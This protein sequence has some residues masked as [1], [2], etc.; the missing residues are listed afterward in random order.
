MAGAGAPATLRPGGRLVPRAA[1]GG[2]EHFS[3]RGGGRVPPP[4]GVSTISPGGGRGGGTSCCAARQLPVVA[5]EPGSSG[6]TASALLLRLTGR[7]WVPEDSGWLLRS[8]WAPVQVSRGAEAAVARS[9]MMLLPAV[10]VGLGPA[11]EDSALLR[12]Q[13]IDVCTDLMITREPGMIALPSPA[14][15]AARAGC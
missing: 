14:G 9:Q 2:V 5:L 6:S 11:L 7:F 13:Y 4:G 3:P 10:R 8:S 12:R 1:C 15:A